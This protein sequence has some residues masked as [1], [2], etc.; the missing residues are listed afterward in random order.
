MK[1]PI[2]DVSP[3][4]QGLLPVPDHAVNGEAAAIEDAEHDTDFLL[5]HIGRSPGRYQLLLF[6]ALCS[7]MFP[8]VFNDLCTIFYAIPPVF[9]YCDITEPVRKKIDP[10][11]NGDLLTTYAAELL[12]TFRSGFDNLT[13][14]TERAGKTQLRVD[15]GD[16][17]SCMVYDGLNDEQTA[18]C[19]ASMEHSFNYSEI[20]SVVSEVR[21]T[22]KQW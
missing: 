15:F 19:D 9:S 5:V 13:D 20:N 17:S 22:L 18:L 1:S 14:A 12:D 8:V 3:L 10:L 21:Y 16:V 11:G 4:H 7:C 2:K 6:T